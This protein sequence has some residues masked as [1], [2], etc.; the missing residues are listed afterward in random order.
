MMM[1]HLI[2]IINMRGWRRKGAR[3]VSSYQATAMATPY[4][5]SLSFFSSYSRKAGLVSASTRLTIIII[6]TVQRV[7]S[8]THVHTG[9]L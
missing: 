4:L 9:T 3:K 7:S 2:L 8:I 6:F 5:F 1:M